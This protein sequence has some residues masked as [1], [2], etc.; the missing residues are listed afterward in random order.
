M[1]V[2]PS[3]AVTT[4]VIVFAPTARLIAPDALP[5]DT[6]APLIL[7]VAFG[8][9]AVGVTVKLVTLFATLAV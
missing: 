2:V 3:C 8:S 9:A 7:M 4:V 6:V 5:D 1:V